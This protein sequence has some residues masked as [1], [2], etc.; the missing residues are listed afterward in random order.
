LQ[1]DGDEKIPE[2]PQSGVQQG[3]LPRLIAQLVG[4]RREVKGLMKG[5]ISPMLMMQ[6]RPPDGSRRAVCRC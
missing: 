6:V 2:V 1:D 3:V 5:K 4:R